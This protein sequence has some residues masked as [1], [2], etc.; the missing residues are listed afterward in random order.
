MRGRRHSAASND[1]DPSFTS[2]STKIDLV[3]APDSLSGWLVDD[4]LAGDRERG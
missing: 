2:L 3:G 1:A 4:D